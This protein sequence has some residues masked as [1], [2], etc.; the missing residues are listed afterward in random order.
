MT[1]AQAY[2]EL[3]VVRPGY[4]DITVREPIPRLLQV[5]VGLMSVYSAMSETMDRLH[6]RAAEA[7]EMSRRNGLMGLQF[8]EGNE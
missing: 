7:V 3:K 4:Q 2:I 8:E 5:S 6:H 1:D